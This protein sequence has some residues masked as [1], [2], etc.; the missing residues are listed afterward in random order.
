MDTKAT[1]A[2]KKILTIPC[3][4]LLAP[5]LALAQN[6][7]FSDIVL[8]G[9]GR[10]IAG[11]SISVCNTPGL[12]TT[13]A[14]VTSNIAVLTFGSSPITAGFAAGMTLQVSGFTGADT[15]FNGGTLSSGVITGGFTILSVTSTTV[16][17]N[18]NHA[19][20]S[21]TSNG[22]AFQQGN[23]VTPCAPLASISSDG[24]GL[25]PIT[26][27]GLVTDG[28]G[29]YSFYAVAN[30][31]IVQFYGATV[32]LKLK[33]IN[34]P[35]GGLVPCGSL[36]VSGAGTFT[37]T[38]P[39]TGLNA[40]IANGVFGVGANISCWAG[41]DLF[42]QQNTVYAAMPTISGSVAGKMVV[43]PNNVGA[44]YIVS[45]QF[46]EG[47][48]GKCASVDWNGATV[49]A[50]SMTSTTPIV[51]DCGQ[52]NV[53]GNP[54]FQNL[55]LIGPCTTTACSGVTS[56]GM[57]WGPTNGLVNATFNNIQIGTTGSGTGFL[58]GIFM[59][60]GNSFLNYC[61]SCVIARNN[62]GVNVTAG[63]GGGIFSG[64]SISQNAT[65]WNIAG[66]GSGKAMLA[67]EFDD[68][69]TT[70]I[71]RASTASTNDEC[72]N[73]RFENAGLGTLPVLT[74]NV[75]TGSMTF[76]GGTVL[77]DVNSGTTPQYIS[78][79][80][81]N[82][83]N[84]S[85]LV[86]RGL[87]FAS[88]GRAATQAVFLGNSTYDLDVVYSGTPPTA[89]YNTNLTGA[90][91]YS[92]DGGTGATRI[93][94]GTFQYLTEF[95]TLDIGSS[96]TNGFHFIP[97]ATGALRN[98]NL[99]ETFQANVDL[100]FLNHGIYNTG[101]LTSFAGTNGILQDA[102]VGIIPPTNVLIS[103]TAPTIA[104][105]GCGG[106]AASITVNNGTAAFKI[107]VGTTPGSACTFTMPTATTGW[108]CFATD[109]T[110]N[111][112]SVFLQ[113]QTGAESTTSVTIT[114]FSDVAVATAFVASDVLKVA[115]T[116]D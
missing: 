78:M 85:T 55:H 115:C 100:G 39:A 47:T 9:S 93:A 35:C 65:G 114:N 60:S 82:N 5:V 67:V 112:T 42:A 89:L 8:S 80:S 27:P 46:L 108:N 90:V 36:T 58:N 86:V 44:A 63:G 84:S 96:A 99:L 59:H 81:A 76:I 17:Y 23:S 43:A 92:I 75:S 30:S 48:N 32:T 51:L 66:A 94:T 68:N 50:S 72:T 73:C 16:T 79:A 52:G 102:G 18:L 101:H 37:G 70:A 106:A 57:D 38:T 116:A 71:N 88:A 87:K 98:V 19:N 40:C 3:L 28:L 41:S 97:G 24:A 113:K 34:L 110:T 54:V 12:V 13:A 105:A 33:P 107:G 91:R 15:Y 10:P 103:P 7:P 22:S 74:D 21:A 111:S 69:T 104:A 11:A 62:T 20:A 61:F 29:N 4:L 109:I 77:D 25:V 45:T 14:S 83:V 53:S 1:R 6:A 56:S 49:N 64:G 2:V 31:Y 26:Q 95:G